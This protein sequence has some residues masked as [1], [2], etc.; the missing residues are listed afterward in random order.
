MLSVTVSQCHLQGGGR[1]G[2]HI[3]DAH[4]GCGF[5]Y[6]LTV[7]LGPSSTS[8]A[9]VSLCSQEPLSWLLCA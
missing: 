7:Q 8:E 6:F 5:E 2:R 1:A 3:A 4:F 9:Q